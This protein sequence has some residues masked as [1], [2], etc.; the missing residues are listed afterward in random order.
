MA[1]LFIQCPGQPDI[2]IP[3]GEKAVTIGRAEDAG[4]FISEKKASRQ[5]L[6]VRTLEGGGAVAEDQGSSNGTWFLEPAGDDQRFLRRALEDGDTLR[7]GDT[8]ITYRQV[9]SAPAPSASGEPAAP[10]LVSGSLMLTPSAPEA[11]APAP[12]E[13]AEPEPVPEPVAASAPRERSRDDMPRA[14]APEPVGWGKVLG[15]VVGAVAVLVA[16]E[17]YWGKQAEKKSARSEEQRAMLKVL[18][19]LDKGLEHF[20]R[21]RDAFADKYPSSSQL[22][23]LDRFLDE[24]RRRE[25][26]RIQIEG[27]LNTLLARVGDAPSSEIRRELEDL[28]VQLH[29]DE[30]FGLRISRTVTGLDR[31][32]AESDEDALRELERRVNAL[33]KADRPSQ[34]QALIVAYRHAHPGLNGDNYTRWNKLDGKVEAV[35]KETFDI[36]WALAED[37]K[38]SGKR[39]RILADVYPALAGSRY[40][41]RVGESLR[42]AASLAAPRRGSLPAGATPWKPG[43]DPTKPA[44]PSH[45]QALLA[46]AKKAETL[47]GERKWGAARAAFDELCKEVKAE[48]LKKEWQVRMG[49]VD[50]ILGLV[51]ALAEETDG[52]KKLRRKLS[53]GT[54]TVVSASPAEVTLERKGQAKVT[55]W[56]QL[57]PGDVL[58]LLKP[59]RMADARRHAVAVLATSLGDRDAFIDAL[60]PL[61]DKGADLAATNALVARHLHGLPEAPTGGYRHYKGEILD[62]AGYERR[63]TQERI[64]TLRKDA[65][66]VLEAMAKEKV[67]KKLQR[68]KDKRA[69]LDKRR[70]YALLAIF[71]TTHYPYPANKGGPQ[72]QAVQREIDR[73][74]ALA[75]EIW[76]DPS[77]MQIKR[78]GKLDKHLTAWDGIIA[79]LKRHEVD[80]ADLVKRI[81]PYTLYVGTDVPLSIRTF[82]KDEFEKEWFAYNRWVM[83][84][85]NPA[86]KEYANER[87][88]QQV[89]VT[90]EYRMLMG[91]HAVVQPGGASYDA[92]DKESVIKILD[93]GKVLKTA[94]LRALRIDNRLVEAARLH[95]IDMGKRGYFAHQAPANPATGEP[96]TGPADRMRKAGYNGFGFSEN[97]AT[98]SD[99]KTAH[100]MWCHSSGHHRNILSNWTD[101]GSGVAGKG[102]TQNFGSGGGSRPQI[103]PDTAIRNRKR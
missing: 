69:E 49:E 90:N 17:L 28:R 78:A 38:D 24:L 51:R 4:A 86:R 102:F 43:Q 33:L 53:G 13:P 9:T 92:I 6:K 31:R 11:A 98:A 62:N 10:P 99:P 93:A 64:A 60:I 101:L 52:D 23:T 29:E 96:A 103:Y 30:E 91:Y 3:L 66:R 44:T 2:T 83:T 19:D 85:Y 25:T 100:V 63:V 56:S 50:M 22:A 59:K 71:N 89:H 81:T 16:V 42:S 68:L 39:T 65:E 36:A 70:K 88:W 76:D 97:I 48:S 79:E 82:Y 7:I 5:H 37:E 20:T 87:E 26:H 95:S 80:T 55:P 41:D 46:R 32:R 40:G 67:F 12:T 8:K 18:E 35:L 15:F 72:Y 27:R 75:R 58:T 94:P 14:R 21:R 34:A 57:A 73:R 1:E 54:Y 84:A 45:T 61:Y 74:I 77:K 47:I